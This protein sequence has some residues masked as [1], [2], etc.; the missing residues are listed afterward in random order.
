MAQMVDIRFNYQIISCPID[1]LYERLKAFSGSLSV[2][3]TKSSGVKRVVYLDV[4]DGVISMSYGEKRLI[5]SNELL[6]L[7]SHN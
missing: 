2:I 4:C 5:N 7:I 3:Y 1:A 6:N